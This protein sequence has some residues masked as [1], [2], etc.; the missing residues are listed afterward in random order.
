[1]VRFPQ[2]KLNIAH[3]CIGAVC[4]EEHQGVRNAKARDDLEHDPGR[5]VG[6]R[7]EDLL[8]HLAA[9]HTPARVE[10]VQIVDHGIHDTA[11]L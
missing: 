1:M 4:A 3:W 7:V 5:G 8:V 10:L 11:A 6:E 2:H 9:H